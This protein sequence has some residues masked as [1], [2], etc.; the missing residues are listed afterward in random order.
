MT[1]AFIFRDVIAVG[2][3]H[4]QVEDIAPGRQV[5]NVGPGQLRDARTGYLIVTALEL[6][7]IPLLVRATR[8]VL[9]DDEDT[10]VPGAW[11]AWAGSFR[12]PWVPRGDRELWVAIAIGVAFAVIA[13]YLI[14]RTGLLVVQ[15]VDP[16][17]RWL[18]DGSVRGFSRAIGAPFGMVPLAMGTRVKGSKGYKPNL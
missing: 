9:A 13:G 14:E 16:D 15:M 1:Y 5:R 11:R 3:I 18:A 8:R 2:E 17:I 6:A 10:V 7:S 12:G 4:D